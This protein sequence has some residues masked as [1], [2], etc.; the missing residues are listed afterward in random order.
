MGWGSLGSRSTIAALA[1]MGCG[2]ASSAN[3]DQ[4]VASYTGGA[5]FSNVA[6]G[7]ITLAGLSNLS[8]SLFAADSANVQTGFGNFTLTLNPV[9]FSGG[10]VGASS[11]PGDS[12][13]LSGLAAGVYSVV[14][15]GTIGSGSSPLPNLA[16]LGMSY[17][18]TA[19]PEAETYA[20]MLA[21]LGVVGFV[22]ARRRRAD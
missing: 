10:A 21:G 13:S 6:L 18:V 1:L 20:M 5:S 19:V 16:I 12:F 17:T 8:G 14:V 22:A 4:L 7:T 3:A 11:F 2:F 9:S 15:S